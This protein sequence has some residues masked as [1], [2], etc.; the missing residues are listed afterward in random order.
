VLLIAYRPR[1]D[2]GVRELPKHVVP[3]T[4]L[5]YN[6]GRGRSGIPETVLARGLGMSKDDA[7]RP[8]LSIFISAG[9]ET[10]TLDEVAGGILDNW[11][12]A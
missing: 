7:L 12:C 4:L 11:N 6:V 10:L 2:T 9:M 5:Y 1:F 8:I 3:A